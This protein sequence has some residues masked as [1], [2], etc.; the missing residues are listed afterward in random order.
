MAQKIEPKKI[1]GSLAALVCTL[2]LTS[3]PAFAAMRPTRPPTASTLLPGVNPSTGQRPVA[4]ALGD[5]N[6]DHKPDLAVLNS[7]DGTVSLFLAKGDGTFT[8]LTPIQTLSSAALLAMG[9]LD[10]DGKQDLA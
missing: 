10:G 9:D 1:L 2:A 3:A 4:V 8:A 5:V 7:G 6:G